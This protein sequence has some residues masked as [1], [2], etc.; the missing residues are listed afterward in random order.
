[1]TANSA[2]VSTATI[3]EPSA[4]PSGR[5]RRMS[6]VL[7]AITLIVACLVVAGVL[8]GSGIANGPNGNAKG[9]FPAIAPDSLV[10]KDA[11]HLYKVFA[12]RPGTTSFAVDTTHLRGGETLFVICDHGSFTV[13][14]VSNRCLG[15]V[16]AVV[17]TAYDRNQS[18]TLRMRVDA[19]QTSTWGVAIYPSAP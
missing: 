19:P 6:F 13:N 10:T 11:T 5:R 18:Y 7:L 12:G 9:L 3:Q 17:H 16:D 4:E 2:P 8:R 14:E 15:H 1:M